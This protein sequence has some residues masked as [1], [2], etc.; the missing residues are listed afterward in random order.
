MLSGKV[1]LVTGGAGG[2]GKAVCQRFAKEGAR[3]AVVDING[4]DAENLAAQLEM[5]HGTNTAT[6]YTVDVSDE[7]AVEACVSA[8]V[9]KH[10]RL[11]V[12]V[13][14]AVR[15]IFGH[16]NPPGTGSGLGTDREVTSEDMSKIMS[17]N[18]NGYISFTKYCARAMYKNEPS[19]PTYENHQ[20]RG[21]STIHA[22]SRGSIINLCS[23]S[24][25]IAQPEFIPYNCSKGALLQLTRCS[26]MD[27]AKLQIR[28]NSISPGSV[29]TEGSH[30]HMSLV[31]LSL[32]EGRKAFG[33]SNLMKRQAAPEEIANGC[34]FLASDESSFMTGSNLVMD[35]GG[36]I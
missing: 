2:I 23:V 24:A 13:N 4:T 14:N 10:G 31:G 26:A 18:V 27:L 16:V 17:V 9:A 11:D 21:S 32:E 29:E 35:G 33:D 12:L 7:K 20:K 8:V 19:G 34:V 15:F 36:T 30:N 1:A 3:V 22:K 6:A 5:L 25:F 28:V